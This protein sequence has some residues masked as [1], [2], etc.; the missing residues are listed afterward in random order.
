MKSIRNR[1]GFVGIGLVDSIVVAGVQPVFDH[2]GLFLIK[3]ML[4]LAKGP[5]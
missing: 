1:F 2:S 3:S 4:K 5:Q